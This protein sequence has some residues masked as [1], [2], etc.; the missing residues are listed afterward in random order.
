MSGSIEVTSNLGANSKLEA[1][2][3]FSVLGNFVSVPSAT[4]AA[5]QQVFVSVNAGEDTGF[6]A[7]N[8]NPAVVDMN[9][10]LI[11]DDGNE[12]AEVDL[13]LD[14]AQ[15]IARFVTEEA[16]FQAYTICPLRQT[17]GGRQRPVASFSGPVDQPG[18]PCHIL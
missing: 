5:V 15:Q 13:S 14:P 16:L 7:Y 4:L 2:E 12:R 1:T 18:S 9:I 10:C 8:P 3:A 17:C 6:A 11:D